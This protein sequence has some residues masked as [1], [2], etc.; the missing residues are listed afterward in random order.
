MNLMMD[1]LHE[2]ETYRTAK[3]IGKFE[4]KSYCGSQEMEKLEML[5][6]KVEKMRINW[7]FSSV[8]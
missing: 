6:L 3:D 2:T 8:E 4:C 7:L 5:L 1:K